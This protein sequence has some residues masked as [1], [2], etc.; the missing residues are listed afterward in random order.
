M[1]HLLR[2]T[3]AILP[4]SLLGSG[5]WLLVQ[6]CRLSNSH[7]GGMLEPALLYG[8]LPALTLWLGSLPVALATWLLW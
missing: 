1:P 6:S 5:L 2:P 3:L 8:V 4:V 7:A